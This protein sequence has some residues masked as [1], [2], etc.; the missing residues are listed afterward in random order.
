MNQR[1]YASMGLFKIVNTNSSTSATMVYDYYIS[2]IFK[3]S[4]ESN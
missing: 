4:L 3:S 1:D 2:I